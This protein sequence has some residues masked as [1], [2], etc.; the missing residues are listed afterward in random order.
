MATNSLKS[1][2]TKLMLSRTCLKCTFFPTHEIE[3]IKLYSFNHEIEEID[4]K[5]N[6]RII[7][8]LTILKNSLTIQLIYIF[9]IIF[10]K[11]N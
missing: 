9:Y 7:I 11:Y 2:F 3:E 1:I 6:V 10:N 4:K 5:K 8:I